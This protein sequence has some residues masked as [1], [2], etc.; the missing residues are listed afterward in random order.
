MESRA[1]KGT[2]ERCQQFDVVRNVSSGQR[3]Q[4]QPGPKIVSTREGK[5]PGIK[6]HGADGLRETDQTL[7]RWK[8]ALDVTGATVGLI[9]TFPILAIVGIL[10]KLVSKG[11]VFF[12]QE[13]VGFKGKTF[14]MW[15]FRTYEVAA[16]STTH[17]LHLI[18]IIVDA[19]E[20]DGISHKPMKKLDRHP[21]IIPFGNVL[22]KTGI[23]ELPQLFNVLQGD[24]SLVGPRPAISYEVEQ[25]SSHHRERLQAMP[26]LTGLWQVSGKNRLSF[27][28]MVDLDVR[29]WMKKNLLLDISIILKTPSA[30]VMQLL[31]AI[32]ERQQNAAAPEADALDEKSDT[33]QECNLLLAIPRSKRNSWLKAGSGSV[34]LKK[35][36]F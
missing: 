21:G 35:G 11:P 17:K 19:R 26:G 6:A 27:N 7:P 8:R 13:R 5:S 1:L 3:T 34:S 2:G 23:D 20:G 16:E 24:M 22:R 33:A 12:K 4:R 14:T 30:I 32:R 31:D 25:Y 15:K 18:K 10:I 28:E 36:K 29:Y 9:L